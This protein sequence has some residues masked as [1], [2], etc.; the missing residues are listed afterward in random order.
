MRSEQ[1][2][3]LN[4]FLTEVDEQ[5]QYQPM[6][7]TVN[8]ELR[9]HIE[10]KVQVYM[11]YG[12]EEIEAYERAVRDMGDASVIGIQMNDAHHLR[13]PKPLLILLCS[14][15]L[16]G[17]IGNLI[18]RGLALEE[19]FYN[20]YFVWGFL[21]LLIV[22]RYGYPCLLKYTEKLILLIFAVGI[23]FVVSRIVLRGLDFPDLPYQFTR[24]YSASIL[25]GILQLAIPTMAVLLYRKRRQGL[26]ALLFISGLSFLFIW[27]NDYAY[28]RDY[29]YI[30][31]L[32]FLFTC[33]GIELYMIQKKFLNIDRK[34]GFAVAII[35]FLAVLS[36]WSTWQGEHLSKNVQLFL[37]PEQ[38]ADNAWEDGY[39]NVLIRNLLGRAE[40]FGKIRLSEEELIRYGTSQWYYEGGD[41]VWDRNGETLE[42]YVRYRMQFLDQPEL[43]DILPQHTLNNYRI[44]WW[45]LNYGWIPGITLTLLLVVAYVMLFV[46]AFKIRNRLGRITALAG[47]TAIGIQ[48]LFYLLGNFGFQFGMF[49]NLPFV[50][51]GIVSITGS[52]LMA[53]LVLSAYRF[54][55][56]VTEKE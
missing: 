46:T 21:V 3:V 26:Y 54:D 11:E 4:R 42:N 48:F 27:L 40:L 18:G 49:G 28:L 50:S 35:S 1:N 19:I 22:M 31:F 16:L 38:Q 5:I 7:A 12:V 53:G 37:Y 36:I 14:L 55:T 29:S 56:V 32:T 8:E 43:R 25:F 34:K 10:D 51:E 45:I 9:A 15:M 47:S 6:H 33:L 17:I 30:P 44:A 39:N 52:T 20:G 24:I 41:A 13:L 23:F 2:E